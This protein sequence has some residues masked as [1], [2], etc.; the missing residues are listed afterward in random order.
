MS[1]LLYHCALQEWI[2][3]AQDE[4]RD[5]L[6][7]LYGP[8]H[9]DTQVQLEIYNQLAGENLGPKLYAFFKEGRLEEYLPSNPLSWTELTDKSI[10]ATI[11]AKLA[12]IHKL[13]VKCL[14][15]KSNWLIDNY[16]Q[17]NEFIVKTT[18][19][20]LLDELKIS[21]ESSRQIADQ[22]IG[23]NFKPEIEFLDSLFNESKSP[24]V[25]SHN[26]LHQNNII[27]LTKTEEE[28]GDDNLQ[29]RVVLI[30][31][32][33]CSYNYRPFD[34]ANHLME[35]CFDYNGDDYPYFNASFERFPSELQQ[36]QFIVQYLRNDATNK[37]PPLNACDI[38]NH[39]NGHTKANTELT[40]GF[41]YAGATDDD[42]EKLY[43]DMQ[44]FLMASNFLWA[45]WAIK[46]ACTSEIDFGYWVSNFLI[47]VVRADFSIF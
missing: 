45:L 15:K 35:W 14:D 20:S 10:S 29:D 2:N 22:L 36:K 13:D 33:Y 23:I 7:R 37:S 39:S 9:G 11:A 6:L 12:A 47:H 17:L 28:A 46:S 30:D 32:E 25:F 19:K 40:N 41:S 43:R 16:T 24:M 18:S 5:V 31:F 27:L 1:N 38:T 3:S 26:D 42:V 21:R 8:S 4:P 34:L 44:P